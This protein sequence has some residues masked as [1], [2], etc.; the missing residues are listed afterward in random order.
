MQSAGR[1][2]TE[3]DWA[4]VHKRYT[5]FSVGVARSIFDFY[6]QRVKDDAQEAKAQ[7][8]PAEKGDGT[9]APTLRLVVGQCAESAA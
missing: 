8:K 2:L 6:R 7:A 1:H 3:R 4:Q 5:G 9:K